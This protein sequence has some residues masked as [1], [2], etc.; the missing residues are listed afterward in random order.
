[1]RCGSSRAWVRTS[2]LLMFVMQ[3]ELTTRYLSG[4][5]QLCYSLIAP[6]HMGV[7]MHRLCT[8]AAPE[9]LSAGP[10]LLTSQQQQ[11]Q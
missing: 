7:F 1:M 10:T 6:T 2:V 9:Q 3:S 8:A 11:Q 4:S 5:V